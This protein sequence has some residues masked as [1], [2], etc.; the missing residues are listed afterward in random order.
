MLPLYG[1]QVLDGNLI[2]NQTPQLLPPVG[3]VHSV[4]AKLGFGHRM[5]IIALDH[6]MQRVPEHHVAILAMKNSG[7]ISRVGTYSE[8]CAARGYVSIHC[9]NVV[10][11]SPIVAPFGAAESGFSTNPISMFR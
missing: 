6:A 11:H 1:E 2:P 9:A 5:A 8:Y 10:G 7:H 4:D 3:A